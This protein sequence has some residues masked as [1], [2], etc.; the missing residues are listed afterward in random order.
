[1]Q[2]P[3][4]TLRSDQ[5][6]PQSRPNFKPNQRNNFKTRAGKQVGN[7]RAN[8]NNHKRVRGN[9]NGLNSTSSAADLCV[10]VS[11]DLALK[12]QISNGITVE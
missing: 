1:M 11:N 6:L 2:K 8:I 3:K 7:K 9:A 10:S 4:N 5:V 12:R